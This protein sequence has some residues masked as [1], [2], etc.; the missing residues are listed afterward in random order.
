M[1]LGVQ[2]LKKDLDPKLTYLDLDDI[3]QFLDRFYMSRI[4]I[5]MLIG[6]HVAMHEPNP[7]PDQIGYIHTKMSPVEVARHA[8]EDARSVCLREYG[9]APEVTVYGDPDFTFP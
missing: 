9:S 5:R 3:H 2:Q 8:S 1:A 7:L 6:Q 4:G